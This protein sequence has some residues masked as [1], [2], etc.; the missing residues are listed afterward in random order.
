MKI[1][2]S[3]PC[4]E[5]GQ[6]IWRSARQLEAWDVKAVLEVYDNTRRVPNLFGA[7]AGVTA[8]TELVQNAACFWKVDDVGIICISPLMA[9]SAHCHITFWDRRLRGR[10][11]LFR[12]LMNRVCAEYQYDTIWTAIPKASRVTLAFAKKLG[13]QPQTEDKERQVLVASAACFT[14]KQPEIRS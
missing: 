8:L 6:I 2:L 4:R 5:D 9:G 7:K 11:E 1:N 12:Q 13:F 10:E 3:A 14:M